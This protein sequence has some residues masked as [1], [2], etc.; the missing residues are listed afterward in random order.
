MNSFFQLTLSLSTGCPFVCLSVCVCLCV[1]WK[2]LSCVCGNHLST[3][4]WDTST[5][6]IMRPALT[7]P[8]SLLVHSHLSL[9]ANILATYPPNNGFPI[10][11]PQTTKDFVRPSPSLSPSSNSLKLQ[12]CLC[13][14]L[15]ITILL[16]QSLSLSL[17][18]CPS[19]Q[20]TTTYTCTCTWP[21]VW[22]M[23]HQPYIVQH[24]TTAVSRLI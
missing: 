13:L 16:S 15:K 8:F 23:H 14:L 2:Q 10:T 3:W 12:V 9:S 7:P 19:A 24:I 5:H 11:Q 18:R 21:H 4:F 22:H 20:S 17:S 6:L 1:S